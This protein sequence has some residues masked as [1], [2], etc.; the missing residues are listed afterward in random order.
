LPLAKVQIENSRGHQMFLKNKIQN[1][2]FSAR[3]PCHP[4]FVWQTASL[5]GKVKMHFRWFELFPIGWTANRK[6]KKAP[7]GGGEKFIIL[8]SAFVH[9]VVLYVYGKPYLHVT[10]IKT[11]KSIWSFSHWL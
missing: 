6:F 8:P 7:F 10:T 1:F 11:F 5:S 2:V 4:L 9:H 3:A